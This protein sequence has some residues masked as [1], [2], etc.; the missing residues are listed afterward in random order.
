MA[1]RFDLPTN[2]LRHWE[3]VGLLTPAR[4]SADR[5]RYARPDI[6]RV[7]AIQ[8]NK[9]AG[10]TLDQIAVLL[11]AGAPE[12]HAVL[13]GP[14]RR[15]RPADGADAD[16][17]GDDR[18]RLQLQGARHR[19]VPGLP[20]ARA[21]PDGG[22]RVKVPA[23]LDAQR[24][25]GPLWVARLDRL[26]APAATILDEWSL[27]TDGEAMHGFCSLVLPVRTNAGAPAVLKLTFDGDDESE[28]EGIALQ[29]WGGHG[30]VRLLRADPHRRALLLERL[31][32][33]DLADLWDVEACEVVAGLYARLHVPAL[34][35]LRTLTSYVDRWTDD[36]Q[37]MPRH[38]PIPRRLV[39]Q[40]TSLARAFVADDA[41]TGVLVHGD[42]HYANVLAADREPWLAI[43]PKPMNGD[44][45]YEPAPMLWNRWDELEGDI[46]GECVAAS[47]RSSTPPASMRTVPGTGWSCGWCSTRTGRWRTPRER[48]GRWPRTSRPGSPAA[49]PSPRLSRTSHCLETDNTYQ[50]VTG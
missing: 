48:A 50:R 19:R 6:V 46:R 40:A 34:P 23:G 7:A 2:V 22:L 15:P 41:S 17:A 16:L 39:E 13:R 49:L 37:R 31:H 24:R 1:Q 42:L 5:R 11:D 47:T 26:P 4:D 12:R 10:M 3:S 20:E 33:E 18:A 32:T 21:R 25:L 44:P 38:A 8:R 28:H 29:R 43:D 30:V 45:H 14:P 35:Q 9:D 36:L 27:T